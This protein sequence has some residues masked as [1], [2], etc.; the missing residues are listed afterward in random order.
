M[1]SLLAWNGFA[2]RLNRRELIIVEHLSLPLTS[3]CSHWYYE[4]FMREANPKL[5]SLPLRKFSAML[6]KSCPMLEQWADQHE[7]AFEKFLHYKTRVPVCGAIMLNP[8]WDKVSGS[9]PTIQF[10]D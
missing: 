2:S 1:K 7:D 10:L 3:S 4:D 9:V 8:A 6:F 5:P